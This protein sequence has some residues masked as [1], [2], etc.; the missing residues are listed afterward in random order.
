MHYRAG[1]YRDWRRI[2]QLIREGFPELPEGMV[3]AYC[4]EHPAIELAVSD[5]VAVGATIGS[6]RPDIDTYWLELITVT[7]GARG[8]GVGRGLL[9]RFEARA[10][11]QGYGRV[12]LVTRPWNAAA[13]N[14]YETTGYRAIARGPREVEFE[15]KL[16]RRGELRRSAAKGRLQRWFDRVAYRGLVTLPENGSPFFRTRGTVATASDGPTIVSLPERHAALPAEPLRVR[17]DLPRHPL[18][19]EQRIKETI[20]RMAADDV[21]IRAVPTIGSGGFERSERIFDLDGVRAF[22]MLGERP[23]WVNLH[24]VERYDAG[25]RDLLASYLRSIATHIGEL[26]PEVYEAGCFLLLSSGRASV[27]FHA[28]PDQSFLNQIRGSKRALVYPAALVPEPTLETLAHTGDHDVV[29]WQP[30]YEA[31]A[32]SIHLTPGDGVLLPLY[33]PHRVEN[34]DAISVSLSIG[35]HTRHSLARSRVHLVNRELRALDRPVTP[36]GVSRFGD[37]LK[38]RLHPGLRIKNK[39]R[40]GT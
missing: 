21:E 33:A 31:Y 13:T 24:H 29:T 6:P 17:H 5:G 11:R 1:G 8:R 7:R 18:F 28:D 27:H 4:R 36:W 39:I 3:S 35:F 37:S 30:E 38:E 22:S 9:E 2:A 26:E 12:A 19:S 32:R 16:A 15:K 25:Y 40:G 14:L 34:D 20:V 10:A 23:L